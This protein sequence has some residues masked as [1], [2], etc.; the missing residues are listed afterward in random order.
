VIKVVY[1]YRIFSL[2]KYG[3][4]SRYICQI[5]SRIA[6]FEEYEVNI[7]AGFYINNY[8]ELFPSNLVQG[9]HVYSIPNTARILNVINSEFSRILLK[10]KCPDIVHETYYS[11]KKLAPK[12]SKTIITVHDMIHEKFSNLIPK[13]QQKISAIK[14]E[15]IKRADYIICVSENTRKDLLD[16]FNIDSNK[17]STI[18]SGY[19]LSNI[20]SVNLT[21]KITTPYI[22]YVGDRRA[23][24][25]NFEKLLKAY[26]SRS[27]IKNNF[28]LVCFGGTP[29]LSSEIDIMREFGINENKLL[30]ISGND[31]ILANL[32]SNASVFVYPSLYEGFG[33]PPLEA[34]S[35]NCPVVCSNVSSIPEVV[36]DAGQY[37]D[38]NDIDSIAD[39]IETVVF[40]EKISQELVM[41]GQNRV[42]YF[43]WE[44]CAEQTSLVYKSLLEKIV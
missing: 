11:P 1:D 32:Y 5:S 7:F 33:I 24:Y 31:T 39:A 16:I 43:S 14:A 21:A 41:K 27:F 23:E 19:A 20:D 15:A 36:A 2:Q 35:F 13:H 40:S 34:M 44:K 17:V 38:P 26:G 4:V 30:H 10:N 29:I 18:Y 42:K 28:N 12:N 25:K 37:F 22:L 3:G 6:N 9:K 8:L